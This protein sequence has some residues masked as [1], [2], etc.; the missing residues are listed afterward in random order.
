MAAKRKNTGSARSRSRARKPSTGARDI[1][2]ELIPGELKVWDPLAGILDTSTAKRLRVFAEAHHGADL[3][4]IV[5]KAVEDFITADL[6]RNQ[7]VAEEM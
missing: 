7:G 6:G 1:I 4:V 3:R 2:G 5:N